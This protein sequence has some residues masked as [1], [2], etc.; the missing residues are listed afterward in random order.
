MNLKV[1]IER[2]LTHG[3]DVTKDGYIINKDQSAY[4][5]SLPNAF[6]H[7][8]ICLEYA[9]S[10]WHEICADHHIYSTLSNNNPPHGLF[11]NSLLGSTY[12]Y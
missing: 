3:W 1:K 12:K 11:I 6:I 4:M 9:L 2:D 7:I 10:L 8:N 5:A